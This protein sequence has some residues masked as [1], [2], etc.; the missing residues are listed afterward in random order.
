MVHI[1]LEMLESGSTI[2]EILRAYPSLT[3]KHIKAS[4]EYAARITERGLDLIPA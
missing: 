4:L 2:D 3:E 1:V